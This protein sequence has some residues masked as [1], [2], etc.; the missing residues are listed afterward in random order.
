MNCLLRGGADNR[1]ALEQLCRHFT[2]PALANQRVQI[3]V[4]RW[5]A[6]KLET[7]WATAQRSW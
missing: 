2:G 6:L 4:G 3:N 1:Q 5:V 7:S